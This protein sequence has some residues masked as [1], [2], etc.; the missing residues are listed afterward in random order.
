MAWLDSKV[1]EFIDWPGK[2][3]DINS[4]A[5]HRNWMKDSSLEISKLPNISK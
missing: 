4:I 1:W 5:N 3:L 2:S